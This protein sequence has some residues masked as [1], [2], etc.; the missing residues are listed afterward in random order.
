MSC[1]R[2]ACTSSKI[3]ITPGGPAQPIDRGVNMAQCLF[4]FVH[5]SNP[6]G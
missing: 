3:E 1:M 2:L 6:H 5:S 4:H